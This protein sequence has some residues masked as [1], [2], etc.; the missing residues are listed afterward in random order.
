[1]AKPFFSRKINVVNRLAM[2]GVA[3]SLLLLMPSLSSAQIIPQTT[4]LFVINATGNFRS[5]TNASMLTNPSVRGIFVSMDWNVLEAIE[6]SYYWSSLD[7]MLSEAGAAGKQVTL[8]VMAGYAT[9][10]WVYADG[11]QPF[12]FL[13]D[14]T[15]GASGAGTCSVQSLP[16]PWDPVFLAKWQTFIQALGARYGSNR[17]LVSVMLYG[18]NFESVETSLPIS[19]GKKIEG[20]GKSCTG[21]N[22]PA[23]WQAAGYTRTK[24]ED[25]LATLQSDYQAAFPNTQLLA[26]LNP[27]GFPPIDQDGNLIAKE[28]A[29]A[30]VPSELMASGAATLGSQFSAGDGGLSATGATWSTL[31]DYASTFDTGYQTTTAL[32]SALPD[33]MDKAIAAGAQWLQLYSS[34]VT[35]SSN[36]SALASAAEQ[37]H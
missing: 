3:L 25:A 19:N 35:L 14:K 24:V 4:G 10:P 15:A 33:A 9:P 18:V 29:D 28:T 12:K 20:E 5:K 32:G 37:L 30:D 31:T 8:G 23:L 22:Y 26:G 36:Q 1:M 21:Y 27:A 13:W 16:I 2:L 6:G 11:A 7:S 34:D 17:T